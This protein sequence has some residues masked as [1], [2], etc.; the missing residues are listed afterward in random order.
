MR[1]STI[2]LLLICGLSLHVSLVGAQERL[3]FLYPSPVGSWFI[4]VITKEAKYFE[5]EGLSVELVRVG[6]VRAGPDRD[7]AEERA[8]GALFDDALE[9]L[10]GRAA[11]RP[12]VDHRR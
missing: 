1:R 3:T 12:V 9:D 8:V 5:R 11:G 7:L 2:F 10:A 6:L 4:P